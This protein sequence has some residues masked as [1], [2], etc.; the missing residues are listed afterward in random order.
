MQNRTQE[1]I[2]AIERSNEIIDEISIINASYYLEKIDNTIKFTL[3]VMNSDFASM[4]GLSGIDISD[5]DLRHIELH[6][7]LIELISV[8]EENLE[9]NFKAIKAGKCVS[10]EMRIKNIKYYEV[11]QLAR[12]KIAEFVTENERMRTEALDDIEK[13]LA[14]GVDPNVPEICCLNDLGKEIS[15]EVY[16][17]HKAKDD[18]TV[19]LLL[20]YKANPTLLG[21]GFH[22]SAHNN[23]F[24]RWDSISPMQAACMHYDL[25]KAMAFLSATPCLINVDLIDKCFLAVVMNI[26]YFNTIKYFRQLDLIKELSKRASTKLLVEQ[27]EFELSQQ[28]CELDHSGLKNYWKIFNHDRTNL[29]SDCLNKKLSLPIWLVLTVGNAQA[30]NA[31][32][33]LPPEL[34]NLIVSMLFHT[35]MYEHAITKMNAAR[36]EVFRQT[37]LMLVENNYREQSDFSNYLNT[38]QSLKAY[39]SRIREE[40]HK[41]F[42]VDGLYEKEEYLITTKAW[43]LANK[44]YNN[45]FSKNNDF[46]EI[47]ANKNKVDTFK[48][49]QT[50]MAEYCQKS[51]NLLHIIG[52][53]NSPQQFIYQLKDIIEKNQDQLTSKAWELTLAHHENLSSENTVLVDELTQWVIENGETSFHSLVTSFYQQ[54]MFESVKGMYGSL[55]KYNIT[56]RLG[57]L[58]ANKAESKLNNKLAM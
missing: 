26:E 57:E 35:D 7:N 28:E 40:V 15:V 20:K 32:S 38:A 46:L 31:L 22:A 2:Q 6:F 55:I 24:I 58:I 48:I 23:Y 12:A 47:A 30:D 14:Q 42:R 29:Y 36:L 4:S 17:L 27:L 19:S 16:P 10:E 1:L 21:Y 33:V 9:E 25:K 11:L 41:E 39:N 5:A 34:I 54:T 53:V 56:N 45:F 18:K 13:L 52:T 8:G 50:V 43:S 44:H 51:K 49:I 37:Y 3:A